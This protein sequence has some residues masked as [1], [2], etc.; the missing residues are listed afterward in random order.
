[1]ITTTSK[2]VN[3]TA[4]KQGS[5]KIFISL[6]NKNILDWTKLKA[7]VNNKSNVHV[8]ILTTFDRVENTVGKRE[9]AGYQHFLLSPQCFQKASVLSQ[10]C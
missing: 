4:V 5:V 1:M 6:S 3:I 8:V 9:N 10:I 2:Y 7:F